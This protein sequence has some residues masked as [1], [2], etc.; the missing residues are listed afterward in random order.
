MLYYPVMLIS[1]FLLLV[2]R[3][4]G[5]GCFFAFLLVGGLKLAGEV[6]VSGLIVISLAGAGS[7]ALMFADRFVKFLVWIDLAG[8]G[9]Q[10]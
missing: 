2:A 3:L 8:D 6:E 5:W 7:A 10:R 1:S 4:F 9:R